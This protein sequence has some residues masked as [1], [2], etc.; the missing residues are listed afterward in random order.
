MLFRSRLDWA[1][2]VTREYGLGDAS[3][4]LKDMKGQAVLKA[5]IRPDA[6]V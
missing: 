3:Q 5:L 4:A 1:G 2:F 6:T